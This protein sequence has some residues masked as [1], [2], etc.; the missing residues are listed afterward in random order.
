MYSQ[1]PKRSFIRKLS[2]LSDKKNSTENRDTIVMRS[3]SIPETFR[4]NK[5]D[6]STLSSGDKKLPPS[7]CD[8][9]SMIHRNYCNRQMGSA[10]NFG[11]HQIPSEK[12]ILSLIFGRWDKKFPKFWWWSLLLFIEASRQINEQLRL[13]PDS[14]DSASV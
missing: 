10:W 1:T 9:V 7:L 3:F 5:R 13:W 2:K 11:K 14:P 12:K 8:T 4:N 6:P